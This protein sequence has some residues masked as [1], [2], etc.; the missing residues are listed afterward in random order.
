MLFS[1]ITFLFF[2]LPLVLA[3]YYFAPRAAKNHVLLAA[4]L[5]FLAW[6]GLNALCIMLGVIAVNYV[7]ALGFSS[8]RWLDKI[9][10]LVSINPA[11][12]AGRKDVLLVT[13]IANFGV[14]FYFKYFN[15]VAGMFGSQANIALPIGIS[16]FTFQAVS[17]L[18]DVYRG[19]VPAEKNPL[20]LALFIA[21]FPQLIAGPIVKYHDINKALDDREILPAD[22]LYGAQRFIIGLAKKVLIANTMG[23]VADRIFDSGIKQIDTPLAW[24]AIAAYTLQILFDFS[25]YS[26]M[27]IGLGR[28]F[29]FHFLENFNYPYI[30]KSITEFWRRWHISLGAWFREYLYIFLGGN[31]TG[32]IYRNLFLV[33]LATGVWHGAAWNFIVWGVWF[34]L[35]IMLEKRIG[36]EKFSGAWA[37]LYTMAVVT[38]SWVMFRA[39]DLKFA[40]R[41]LRAMLGAWRGESPYEVAYFFD[42]LEIVTFIAAIFLCL[43]IFR[44]ILQTRWQWPLHVWLL[45]LFVLSA[46]AIAS[47]TYNPFIYFRF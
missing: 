26:D 3:A 16:F 27:A 10:Q 41:F 35:F 7:G 17:Y 34:G 36:V 38:V 42:R 46:S 13:L 18:L 6:G 32:N 11:A 12:R 14:L 5:L 44:N 2:F 30:S 19:E 33:F 23:A 29:G 40:A 4:S 47:G 20:K 28:V 21:M 39:P 22:I 9:T 37:H 15:F 8:P 43:P 25:G 24:V 45:I 1:S 31:R